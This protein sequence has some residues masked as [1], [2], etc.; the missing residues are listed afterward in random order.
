MRRFTI[1]IAVFALSVTT[2]LAQQGTG[3]GSSRPRTAPDAPRL[4]PPMRVSGE[5]LQI[6]TTR[7]AIQV[8]VKVRNNKRNMG[9]ALDEKC[10][11]KADKKQ[12]G[13]KELELGELQ[14]GYEVE[15]TI[16]QTDRKVV[17][18]KV[19]KPKEDEG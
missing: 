16:R 13:K 8:S 4:A 15:L 18:M 17:E 12:F 19:K 7:N 1:A 11:I 3:V 9:F 2:I 10:K 14:P 5:V 6:D